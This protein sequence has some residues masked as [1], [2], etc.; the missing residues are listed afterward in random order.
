[1]SY[2]KIL[3]ANLCSKMDEWNKNWEK[4]VESAC[5]INQLKKRR[6]KIKFTDNDIFEG[7]L[8]GILSSNTDWRTIRKIKDELK[9][10]F[11]NFDLDSYSKKSEVYITNSIVPWFKSKK[12]GSLTLNRN[13]RYLIDTSKKLAKYSNKYGSADQ[14]F[15]KALAEANNDA[16]EL[17][18]LLGTST[19][20]KLKGF[21]VPLAA[22]ALRNIGYNLSKPDRHILRAV[23]SFKLVNFDNW[24]NRTGRNA[25][26]PSISNHRKAMIAV[27]KLAKENNKETTF[28]DSVIWTAC[29][30]GGAWLT[31]KELT[32]IG[33]RSKI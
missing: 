12:A 28:V 3:W 8:L 10:K 25:P 16:I 29:A 9:D 20:W 2:E 24:D 31:N 4:E 21:G 27:D 15:T 6:K 33:N 1:M 23:G 11:N 17:A 26:K 14:Y 19:E 18:I 5:Y 7:L 30:K 32:E 13:L 22:E